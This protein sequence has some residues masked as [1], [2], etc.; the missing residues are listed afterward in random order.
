MPDTT[1]SSGPP[2]TEIYPGG[3]LPDHCSGGAV[4]GAAGGKARLLDSP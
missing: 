1:H 3:E 2:K 4:D